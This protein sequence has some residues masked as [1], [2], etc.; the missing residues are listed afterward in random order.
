MCS[1]G[2]RTY[3]GSKFC[4]RSVGHQQPREPTA[5]TGLLVFPP[6]LESRKIHQTLAKGTTAARMKRSSSCAGAQTCRR[7]PGLSGTYRTVLL[8]RSV[9]E[10][11]ANTVAGRTER[12]DRTGTGRWQEVCAHRTLFSLPFPRVLQNHPASK[13]A[14][15]SLAAAGPRCQNVPPCWCN[16]L[17]QAEHRQCTWRHQFSLPHP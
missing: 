13:A 2:T 6:R 3:N 17:A 8:H 14:R 10:L 9:S 7:S 16:T 5:R 4:S 12:C 1:T 15:E 11:F